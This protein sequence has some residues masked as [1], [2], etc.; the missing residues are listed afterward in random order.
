M[1]YAE[2]RDLPSY[3]ST[4]LRKDDA[5]ASAAASLGWARQKPSTPTTEPFA[6]TK[7]ASSAAAFAA[8]NSRRTSMPEGSSASSKAAI[9]AAG[10]APKHHVA[11]SHATSRQSTPRTSKGDWGSSAANQA[12]KS[13]KSHMSSR[14]SASATSV[15][16]G[17]DDGRSLAAARGAVSGMRPRSV[18]SPMETSPDGGSSTAAANALSAATL[19]HRPSMV[20]R[21][22]EKDNTGTSPAVTMARQMF[23]AN[24]PVKPE[25]DAQQEATMRRASAVAMA[26][27][28]YNQQQKMMEQAA[29]NKQ[30]QDTESIVSEDDQHRPLNLQQ[31]A[32]KMAQDRLQKLHQELQKNRDQ[33]Y[34]GQAKLRRR[35]SSANDDL[36]EAARRNVKAQMRG[37]DEK[38]YAETG[39]VTPSL[40]SDW[41][42]RA[43]AQAQ[44][45]AL[46]KSE[47]RNENKGRLDVGGGM[48]MDKADVDAIAQKRVQPLLDDIN[49]KA[50]AERERL[51][52]LKAEQEAKRDETERQRTRERE[53]KEE[54]RQEKGKYQPFIPCC[55]VGNL[56]TQ[57][58]QKKKRPKRE[59]NASKEK[60]REKQNAKKRKC[61]VDWKRGTTRQ[62]ARARESLRQLPRQSIP[63]KPPRMPAATKPA[64]PKKG[65]LPPAPR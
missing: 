36:L 11:S 29:S 4:G 26:R 60:T 48:F 9:M 2:P 13:S 30:T 17:G 55:L 18:S 28:M 6:S 43:H 58:Q 42:Q 23:T 59:P 64:L 12:F 41:D 25:I 62:R 56:T 20:S 35:A 8:D 51:A 1:K 54:A 22:K 45:L 38:V 16:G 46:A 27:T 32:Y 52:T 49:H 21:A 5:A 39:K 37:M 63:R 7:S 61:L 3:P 31:A 53:T 24:P 33:D 14:T 34:S 40:K 15:S 65:C 44:A 19:A 10:V 50:E 57:N 47:K